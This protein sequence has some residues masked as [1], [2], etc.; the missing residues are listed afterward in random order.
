MLYIHHGRGGNA[1]QN[2]TRNGGWYGVGPLSGGS[3]IFVSPQG[4][5]DG[6]TTGWLNTGGRDVAFLRV[7]VTQIN[8]KFCA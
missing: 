3:V 8:A 5:G 1:E 6:T 4:D 7:L 2:I